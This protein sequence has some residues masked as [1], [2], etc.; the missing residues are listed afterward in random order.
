MLPVFRLKEKYL[1]FTYIPNTMHIKSVHN[2]CEIIKFNAR[3]LQKFS[4]ANAEY[5]LSI[6]QQEFR[7]RKYV[8]GVVKR[9]VLL[10]PCKI[11][12]EFADSLTIKQLCFANEQKLEVEYC[13]AQN[14]VTDG[15]IMGTLFVAYNRD[16]YK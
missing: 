8:Q 10:Q 12:S 2:N 11:N 7:G 3:R 6:S 14:F 4:T 9:S 1:N 5:L 15:S 16:T 13:D